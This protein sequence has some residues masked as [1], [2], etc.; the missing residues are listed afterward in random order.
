MSRL[1][2]LSFMTRKPAS[3]TL[4]HGSELGPVQEVE[5]RM[6]SDV[7]KASSHLSPYHD[8][9]R[10]TPLA[11]SVTGTFQG[12]GSTP[13]TDLA[14]VGP[15]VTI[16]VKTSGLLL[17]GLHAR[18]T[19]DTAA[20]GAVMGF[21]LSGANT[22]AASNDY[23]LE[24]IVDTANAQSSVGTSFLLMDLAPGLTTVTAKYHTSGPAG[25]VASF[26]NRRIYALPL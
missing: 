26:G 13:F 3:A 2:H 24:F 17:V 12:T 6:F 11:A 4:T 15:T 5:G 10:G 23:G 16:P 18:V 20:A 22:L 19:S 8:V 7:Q 9:A 25:A 14:T 21:V 1:S